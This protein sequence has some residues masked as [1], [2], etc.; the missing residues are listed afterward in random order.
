[1]GFPQPAYD[2]SA[3]SEDMPTSTTETIAVNFWRPELDYIQ[4]VVDVKF[5]HDPRRAVVTWASIVWRSYTEP[6][7]GRTGIGTLR[8]THQ[9]DLRPIPFRGYGRENLLLCG[10]GSHQGA[11]GDGQEAISWRDPRAL[12]RTSLT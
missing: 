4:S 3:L 10:W 2:I 6:R 11:C 9:T 1:M 12:V 7:A 5:V 8:E